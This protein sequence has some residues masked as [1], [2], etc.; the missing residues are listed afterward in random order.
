MTATKIKHHPELNEIIKCRENPYYFATKYLTV[1]G[2]PFT[3]L[4]T[5]QEFNKQVKDYLKD[6]VNET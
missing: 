5:E 3:T 1:N 6:R 2:K 4:L